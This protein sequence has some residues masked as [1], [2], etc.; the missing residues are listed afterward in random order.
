MS[1]SEGNEIVIVPSGGLVR[2][3]SDSTHATVV[4]GANVHNVI[5][6]G[7][8]DLD[9]EFYVCDPNHVKYALT[10]RAD[11]ITVR[12]CRFRAGECKGI[13]VDVGSFVTVDNVNFYNCEF[14]DSNS[15]QGTQQNMY[16]GPG[17]PSTI[18]N[19]SVKNCIF[20]DLGGEGIELN[21]R[22]LM[23]NMVISGNIFHN[24]GKQTC[25]DTFACR[26]AI[27]VSRIAVDDIVQD[28][29]IYNNIMW[30]LGASGIY[31]RAGEDRLYI[32][33]NTIYD[34]ANNPEGSPYPGDQEGVSDYGTPDSTAWVVN[35][36]IYDPDGT[37]A[38]DS[39]PY[40]KLTNLTT[41]PPFISVDPTS[42]DFLKI[43]TNSA[44]YNTGTDV[45][46]D[47][48]LPVTTDFEGDTITVRNDIGA[49]EYTAVETPEESGISVT[50]VKSETGASLVKSETGTT[51][52]K[53]E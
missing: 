22:T 12:R 9:I 36:I 47:G 5:I 18:T 46:S 34:Y 2:F 39:G 30:D 11:D 37:A 26:P 31:A 32:Y 42:G 49:D 43:G 15:N 3:S 52:L 7:G 40:N 4:Q 20:R 8:A 53:A 27:T 38:F 14:Y 41:N 24:I 29:Y 1:G 10:I 45:Y 21:I 28:V 17:D 16:W 19:C 48:S 23:S 25:Y 51:I 6:D 50:I 33:D 44:A 35:N 13:L